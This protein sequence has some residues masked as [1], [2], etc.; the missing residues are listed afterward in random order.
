M[1]YV[2]APHN[3]LYHPAHRS[4]HL[5]SAK[6]FYL[7]GVTSRYEYVIIC[8]GATV[9]VCELISTFIPHSIFIINGIVYPWWFLSL[10]MLVKGVPRR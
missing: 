7:H 6:G 1:A 3:K 2:I 5:F 10:S 9:D 8:N 4:C